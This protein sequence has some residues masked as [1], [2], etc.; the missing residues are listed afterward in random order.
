MA[1]LRVNEPGWAPVAG[2]LKALVDGAWVPV[3][4]AD[5]E[6]G[7]PMEG[8]TG[9]KAAHGGDLYIPVQA[10]RVGASEFVLFAL[11]A[12]GMTATLPSLMYDSAGQ[13]WQKVGTGSPLVATDAYMFRYRCTE[14]RTVS[15]AYI[16]TYNGTVADSYAVEY[17]W[18]WNLYG[19]GWLAEGPSTVPFDDTYGGYSKPPGW[20]SG[21]PEERVGGFYPSS[22]G[23]APP[24]APL[25]GDYTVWMGVP[26]WDYSS[27]RLTVG[28]EWTAGDAPTISAS[29]E[30]MWKLTASDPLSA[31]YYAPGDPFTGIWR[32]WPDGRGAARIQVTDPESHTID[33]NSL[34]VDLRVFGVTT[35]GSTAASAYTPA[36]FS[37]L[38]PATGGLPVRYNNGAGWSDVATC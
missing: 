26:K 31:V 25:P 24:D 28:P 20:V 17:L 30:W 4:G 38:P 32:T 12:P 7:T 21:D 22:G 5:P 15:V 18:G 3:C 27:P 34:S 19:A 6:P 23:F 35:G 36:D 33:M 11:S 1:L 37:G 13:K 29:S 9:S 8:F 14:F 2:R 16:S 10:T